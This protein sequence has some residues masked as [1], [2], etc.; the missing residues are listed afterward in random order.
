LVEI[1]RARI[2]DADGLRLLLRS[3]AREVEPWIQEATIQLGKERE[4]IENFVKDDREHSASGKFLFFAFDGKRLV[5]HVNGMSW[6]HAPKDVFDRMIKEQR[7][8]GERPGH[9]GIA[10][11]KD[12][13]RQGIG[14]KLMIKALS[15]LQEMGST[16]AVA[17]VNVDNRP[18]LLFLR[19]MGFTDYR[20]EGNQVL[21]TR[22]IE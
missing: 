18:S 13:R 15:E 19:G 14:T 16:V 4:W 3:L 2:E 1:R 17:N 21:L 12:Y 5:G 22:K 7:L 10:V 6:T 20:R 8:E 11:H 9:I